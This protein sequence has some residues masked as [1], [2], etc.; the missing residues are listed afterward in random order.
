MT[1]LAL[2]VTQRFVSR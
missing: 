1:L 2:E